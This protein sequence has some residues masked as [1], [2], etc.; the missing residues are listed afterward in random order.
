[1]HTNFLKL[2]D[3]KTEYIIIGTYKN[4]QYVAD[5]DIT[6]GDETITASDFMRDLGLWFDKKLKGTV[7]I[8]KITSSCIYTIRNVARIRHLLDL[9]TMKT[10][11]QALVLS[12]MDYC[13]SLLLGCSDYLLQKLQHIQ[14]MA[15]RVVCQCSKF[16]HISPFLADIHWLKVKERIDYKV[17]TI[18]H[19]CVNG[20]ALGYLTELLDIDPEADPTLGQHERR[21]HSNHMCY[22]KTT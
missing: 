4:L 16:K 15:C 3:E 5:T 21:L 6:I 1:M 14:N 9:D 10:L 17:L 20:Q 13:N 7:H 2:N 19:K 18:M 8:N 11:M 22:L 12:H